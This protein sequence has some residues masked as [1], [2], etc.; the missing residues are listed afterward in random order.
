MER[1]SAIQSISFVYTSI[2]E[3]HK[4]ISDLFYKLRTEHA[5]QSFLN[6]LID[7]QLWEKSCSVHP[8]FSLK[9]V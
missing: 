9:K 6:S 1:I 4:R 3:L 7:K 2:Q 8:S 5:K